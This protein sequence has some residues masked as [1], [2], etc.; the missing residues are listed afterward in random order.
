MQSESKGDQYWRGLNAVGILHWPDFTT[1]Q[2]RF[3]KSFVER[4]PGATIF[5]VG[6]HFGDHATLVK[7]LDPTANVHAF[8]PHPVTFSALKAAA[9]EHGFVP[10][11]LALGE[12]VGSIDLFDYSTEMGSGHASF[13][14]EA[15]ELLHQ[16][17]AS[18]IAVPSDTVDGVARK[19]KL[20]HLNLLKIDVQGHELPVIRGAADLIKKQMVDIIQFEF[21]A[22]HVVSRTFFKDFVEV[23]PDYRFFRL[24][25]DSVIDLGEYSP[26][27]FEIFAFQSIISVRGNQPLNW[28]YS[29]S[30]GSTHASVPKS[31]P[32]AV[33]LVS[34][35]ISKTMI[36]TSR[37]PFIRAL[38]KKNNPVRGD[39][40]TT[41]D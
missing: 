6:A 15:I 24:L 39:M 16:K 36:N 22:L 11:Q 20:K 12:S 40:L 29:G 7:K 32:V 30:L 18:Q 3:L 1:G 9:A 2:L 14:R 21:S 34:I 8:E 33:P 41:S 17:K 10:H 25:S 26:E 23:L 13:Y 37:R 5:D 27:W 31:V 4:C 38:R 19:L 35:V 28:L